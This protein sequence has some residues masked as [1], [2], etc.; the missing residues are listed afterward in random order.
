MSGSDASGVADVSVS[1]APSTTEHAATRKNPYVGPRP[2]QI[3]EKLYGRRRELAELRDLLISERIVM[4]YSPSGA[5]KTSLIQAELVP[6]LIA[7][8]FRI[9]PVIRVHRNP[10]ALPL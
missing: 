6:A 10:D 4:L 5:G 8:G 9:W 7:E 2:Y 3:G 1:E